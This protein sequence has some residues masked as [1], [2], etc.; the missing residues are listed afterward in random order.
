MTLPKRNIR[1]A[2]AEKGKFY[3]T[4]AIPYLNGALH[5]GHALE[6][7]QAGVIA[8]YQRMIGRDVFFLTGSDEHGAK[9][10]RSAE[11]AGKQP[12]EFVD[13]QVAVFQKLL[14]ALTISNDDFIRTSDE[15]RHFPGAQKLWMALYSAG[16]IY[17][18]SYKGLYCV[19][20]EAFITEKDL[21][22]GMC[23]DHK[24]PPEVI[25]EE[26]YFFRLTK[27]ADRIKE[28]IEKETLV[29]LPESRKNETLK[30]LEEASDVS[31]S[32]PSK[33]I[34]WGVPV[35]HDATQTMYVWCDALSNYM[36]GIG[37]GRDADNFNR[38]WPADIHVIGKDIMRFHTLIWP[39]MLMS[40]NIELPKTIFVHGW[41]NLK[42]E[43]MSKSTGNVLDPMVPITKF[44]S[45][46]LRFYLIHEVPTFGDGDF[47]PEQFQNTY[48]GLLVS[49]IG[50]LLSRT[51]KMVSSVGLVPKPSSEDGV[52]YPFKVSLG[53]LAAKK[54]H[55]LIEGSVPSV[56]VDDVLES[57]YHA[58]MQKYELSDSIKRIWTLFHMLDQY[59]EEYKI[60]KMIK[61]EPEEAKIALWH[62]SY[63]L[64]SAA[65]LLK[66]FL[67]DTADKILTTLGVAGI[68]KELW[69][70]FKV[71]EISHLFPKI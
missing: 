12:K 22:D 54:E 61:S 68:S 69:R 19:G 13:E 62:V 24:K 3:I 57:A 36:T 34:S 15:K 23:T 16:D 42:G 18:G 43:K 29:I 26:N 60:Y 56:W 20:H 37:Y 47:T 8:R 31:F 21:V 5:L 32:R 64:A 41:I 58:M 11:A 52:R 7:V 30:M 39:A 33:D 65:L 70:E 17:K 46:A 48:D 38:W 59:I 66:P 45:E 27:Y 49:G 51:A 35:P 67:P 25:E 4:S 40:A 50:N 63:A 44:G 53:E 28:A 2:M 10:A 55:A 1:K 71:G 6:Y 9:I 14:H